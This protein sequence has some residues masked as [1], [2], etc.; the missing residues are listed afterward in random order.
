MHLK[1]TL[2]IT[3]FSK[4]DMNKKTMNKT[5]LFKSFGHRL[6]FSRKE[7]VKNGLRLILCR[8]LKKYQ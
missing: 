3:G 5:I 6:I 8:K 7:R 1:K 4:S 2:E